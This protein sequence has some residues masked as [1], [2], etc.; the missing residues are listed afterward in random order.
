MLDD[1]WEKAEERG[2]LAT[3]NRLEARVWLD[4]PAAA[5][6]RVSGAPRDLFLEMNGRALDADD[7]GES[8]DDVGGVGPACRDRCTDAAAGR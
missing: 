2:D 7:P 4:G 8:R 1:E 5:E 6:G 3:V